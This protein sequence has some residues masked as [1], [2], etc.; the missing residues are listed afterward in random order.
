MCRSTRRTDLTMKVS[1]AANIIN[2]TGNAIGIFLLHAGVTGVAYPTLI[3]RIFSAVVMTAVCF[4]QAQAVSYQW[5]N[6]WAHI[7]NCNPQRGRKRSVSACKGSTQQYH[8][9]F[10]H[11]ADRCQWNCTEFLVPGCNDWSDNGT[12]F[13]YRSWTVYGKRRHRSGR[14]LF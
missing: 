11:R 6:I 9:T 4:D 1:I 8:S 2:V 12:G 10:W 3:A 5:K 7:E 13:H 14:V